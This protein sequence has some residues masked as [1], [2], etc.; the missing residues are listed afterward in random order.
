MTDDLFNYEGFAEL[1]KLPI[2]DA[3]KKI[4]EMLPKDDSLGVFNISADDWDDGS[5][6]GGQFFGDV[7]ISKEF[8]NKFDMDIYDVKANSCVEALSYISSI[9]VENGG[10]GY[11][12]PQFGFSFNGIGY[13]YRINKILTES[14]D[15]LIDDVEN[16]ENQKI[17][18]LASYALRKVQNFNSILSKAFFSHF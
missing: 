17:L 1:T 18:V 14:T 11:R 6:E 16:E 5:K 3:F 10:F 12:D 7:I 4:D 2:K 13:E 8:D 15:K 9:L